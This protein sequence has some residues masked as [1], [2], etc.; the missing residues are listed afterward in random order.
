MELTLELAE[1]FLAAQPFSVLLGARLT[2]FGASGATGVTFAD[3]FSDNSI[4]EADIVFN[5]V[6]FAW[7][8]DYNNPVQTSQFVESVALHEIGHFIGL[9][10]SP[11]GSA[12]MFARGAAGVNP[13][14]EL[15]ADEVTAARYLYPNAALAATFA[16]LA[17]QVTMN[18]TGVFGAVVIAED[19]AGNVAG[20]TVTRTN[21]QYEIPS[22]APGNYNVRAVP[23]DPATGISND[24]LVTGRDI[25]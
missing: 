16:R 23:L 25:E 24:H 12:T 21:G 4:A 22:L 15:S 8:T 11:C 10:H 19:I 14:S 6:D 5:G 9:D 1:K 2:A 17:G 13:Q 3:Y 20:G 7:F 18:S